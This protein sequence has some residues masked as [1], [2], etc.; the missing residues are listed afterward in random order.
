LKLAGPSAAGQLHPITPSRVYDSRYTA[1]VDAGPGQIGQG[2]A[3][4][5]SV[6]NAYA[7]ESATVAQTDVVPVG[8]TAIAYN[9]TIVNTGASGFLSVNPGGTPALT[10]SSINWSS[11]GT[12]LAN[13]S[14]VGLDAARQIKVFCG[15]TPTDFIIDV[16]GYYR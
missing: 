6:A 14:V 9:V 2:T 4:T 8:A 15:G 7:V 10:A 11:P 1:A 3:R 16:A 5:I 13:A 12:V